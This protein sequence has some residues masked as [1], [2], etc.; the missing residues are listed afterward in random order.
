MI[1]I[2][3]HRSAALAARKRRDLEKQYFVVRLLSRRNA[4]GAYRSNG[5]TYVWE[6]FD[7]PEGKKIEIVVHFDYGTKKNRNLIQF[8]VHIFGPSEATDS[9]VVEAVRQ[10]E[11]GKKPQGWSW[12]EIF[13]AHPPKFAAS[14]PIEEDEEEG[15]SEDA[16][17]LRPARRAAIFGP[18]EVSITRKNPVRKSGSARRKT[19]LKEGDA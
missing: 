17:K 8:Q 10:F 9:E 4:A 5:H 7:K 14:G 15:E 6:V 13:W 19:K 2:S 16:A 11:R 1:I 12:K 18:D 3:H